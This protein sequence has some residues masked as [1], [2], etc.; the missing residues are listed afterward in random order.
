MLLLTSQLPALEQVASTEPGDAEGREPP[1]TDTD[2]DGIPD[3]HENLFAAWSNRTAV[4]GRRVEVQGLDRTNASDATSDRDRDGLNATEEFC[5]PYPATCTSEAFDR[6]LT[7][8]LGSDGERQYLDPTRAD[9]DGDGLPDGFEVTMCRLDA[10]YDELA[11]IHIC[12]RFDP[13]NASDAELDSDEDGHDV[14]RDGILT[15]AERY[16]NA[17]E[18][19]YGT[20][21]N[22]TTELDGLWCVMTPPSVQNFSVWPYLLPDLPNIG[23]ACGDRVDRALEDDIWLGTNPLRSDSD[24]FQWDG[25]AHRRLHPS[26]GDGMTDGW[27]VHFGL[28]PLNRSDAL[29]DVEPDGWDLDRNGVI[30]PDVSRSEVAMA[31]G[32]AL[33]SFEEYL[34][35]LDGGNTVR[36]GLRTVTLGAAQADIV[37]LP[38]SLDPSVG[39][40]MRVLHHDVRTLD[41]M[42]GR[43]LV[44]TKI[45]MSVLDVDEGRTTDHP[46][47][48]G[49]RL[50]DLVVL[51]ERAVIVGTDRG[52]ISIPLESDLLTPS[53][54]WHRWDGPGIDVL[55]VLMDL[56]SEPRVIGFGPEGA[57][58]MISVNDDGSFGTELELSEELHQALLDRN[59]TVT[60]ILHG[61]AAGTGGV[62]YLGTDRGLIVTPTPDALGA[63]TPSW[64]FFNSPEPTLIP[65]DRLDLRDMI[66]G[67]DGNPAH[68]QVMRFDGPTLEAGE[69]MVPTVLWFG[70]PSG[71]H[72]MDL[73]TGSI[74]HSGD[75]AWGGTD[76]AGVD[77]VNDVTAITVT[78]EFVHVGSRWGTWSILGHG[79]QT[80]EYDQTLQ[81]QVPGDVAALHVHLDGTGTSSLFVG[82]NPGRFSNL[83]AMDP[84]SNDSDADGL[85][86]G[87]EV[88]Y[89]LDPT[90]PWDA[91][92]DPDGDGLDLDPLLDGF[93]DRAWRNIDEYRYTPIG[94]A[95][96]SSTD[97]RDPDTDD[98]GLPDGGEAFGF[99]LEQTTFG[100]HYLPN[101]TLRCD[102][103]L[104]TTAREVYRSTDGIDAPTSATE[105]D[106]DGDGMPDGWEILH[107]R[108]VGSTFTGGNNW[109]L[110]PN[111][112]EDALWDADGD[113]LVNL[114]EYRW[115]ELLASA[116][117]GAFFDSH[118]ESA[119]SAAAWTPLDPN[120]IDS[121]G[122]SLPDGWESRGA[123]SWDVEHAGVNPLNGSDAFQ[124][125][126]GDGFDV[127]LNG[128]LE[129]EEQFVNW[130][131][132]HLR[133]GLWVG[134]QSLDGDP[135]PNN[136][137]TDL[138]RNI[139]S[140]G[141]PL[142]RFDQRADAASLGT[143]SRLDR[144]SSD[145][146][147]PDTDGDGMPDGWEVWFARWDVLR[148]DFTLNPLNASDAWGDPDEDGY[149]NWEEYNSID[150]R[151]T[152]TNRNRSSPQ[153]Y[154][155]RQP[156]TNQFVPQQWTAISHDAS[157]GRFV[158]AEQYARS[159]PTAD[160]NDPDSDGDG[161]L[162]GVE[163]L[164]A[165][166]NATLSIWTLNPLVAGDGGLDSDADGLADRLELTLADA[167][168]ENGG[169]PPVD[170]PLLH[171]DAALQTNPI[172]QQIRVFQI[173]DTKSNRG[174]RFVSDYVDWANGL[175][176]TPFLEVLLAV[177][178]PGNEDTDLDNMSDGFEYWFTEWDLNGN[179]W[180][181]NPLANDDA[182][183]DADGDSYDCDRDGEIEA[184]ERYTNVREFEARYWGRQD[185][186]FTFPSGTTFVGFGEDGLN[187]IVDG[188][189]TPF[190]ARA[191]MVDAFIRASPIGAERIAAINTFDPRAFNTTL[192]GISDPTSEDSDGDGMP[193]G[194][195]YCYAS[196]TRFDIG[197]HWST[198][199][200][201][202]LDG[203]Y[204]PD[205]DGW[206]ERDTLDV[207]A[208]Q[209]QWRDRI[210]VPSGVIIPPGPGDLPFTNRMEFE[211]GTRPDTNDTDGDARNYRTVASGTTVTSHVRDWGLTDG[212]EV[213]KFGTNPID[214]DTDGD[215][216]P[217]FWEYHIGWNE[218]NDNWSSL[219]QVRVV[220]IDTATGA[221]CTLTTLNCLPLRSQDG[222]LS[223]PD[224][225]FTWVHMDPRDPNDAGEDPDQDG[226]WTCTGA[227]CIYTPY[228]NFQEF[229]A[230]ADPDLTSASAVR[231]AGLSHLG[232]PVREWW[233]FRA[234]RLGLGTFD[235]YETNYLRMVRANSS[236]AQFVA[237][238]DDRDTDFLTIDPSD[239][240]PLCLGNWTDAWDIVFPLSPFSAPVIGV[241]EHEFGWWRLDV[242]N[243][244]IAE[245]TDPLDWDTDGDWLVDFFEVEDDEEDGIRGDSSPLRYDSRTT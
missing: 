24:R 172:D 112:P 102:E 185:R 7:G 117:D 216:L 71:L 34:I 222:T 176:P 200:L 195:E 76:A 174:Q 109:S 243:D 161:M 238:Y 137:T 64:R 228:T 156:V 168:P 104:N 69:P 28:D 182:Q 152:E 105:A 224:L 68:V 192:F 11:Q 72:R 231:V 44:G 244:H 139:S 12:D 89:G 129:P 237:I 74:D 234:E 147:D 212:L 45:G 21:S 217:D 120:S 241:G 183:L 108:W 116:R 153:F 5:W 214:N 19:A 65:S 171:V 121:D 225:E 52:L 50:H 126:D 59:A 189:S 198:N 180:T 48:E 40:E 193:D 154:V 233:Q 188:G 32:E 163:S 106:S 86:D 159:G 67:G 144:G 199:P 173:I 136:W 99:F 128:V 17:E 90:D 62:L 230:I 23:P 73:A 242:D 118:G 41:P 191:Q 181:L 119:I 196:W 80:L 194:W 2:L 134:N 177:S 39:E 114:C 51:E 85:P 158:T 47:P 138:F 166:W 92:L 226:R 155:V 205:R 207:P 235:E 54:T 140:S 91:Q 20:P 57:V 186:S 53:T 127:N 208:A 151:I 83:E 100:C 38:L 95:G 115:T 10:G 37:D 209:G 97:P 107:R 58:V 66:G 227:S 236:D 170:A 178:D 206:Y 13:L 98:D 103:G 61:N 203:A 162:D 18:Y 6:S 49:E 239:D 167:Q 60:S 46:L 4:D 204:D 142:A 221:S 3:V 1:S 169:S 42:G 165:V 143:G 229:Y 184:S 56:G 30:S 25:F 148:D 125:P 213:F 55:G 157:F 149:L 29:L 175:P 123:C 133:D 146:T 87:W 31:A 132:Y 145:P 78:E 94:S 187:A 240:V 22:W 197:D 15:V 219:K 201:N 135:I 218:S 141:Q 81:Q 43:V 88:A 63:T 111:R 190:S 179:R 9:T 35:H 210:F 8:V 93:L 110:D 122:D 84:T 211:N 75:L 130:L 82:L 215:M 245:G 79:S 77:V 150:P 223:R 16:T 164:F 101:M 14:D 131:E 160:P 220:W 27:E 96:L 232:Q 36:S 202:P 124:N 33:V 26:Q 70:T 113:G